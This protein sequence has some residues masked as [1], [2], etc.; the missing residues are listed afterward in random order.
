MNKINKI[1]IWV[2]ALLLVLNITTIGTILYHNNQE[3]E[4]NIAIVLDENQAPLTGRYLRQTL[5]F[6]SEQM[7]VFQKTNREFQP[8]ANRIIYEMDSLKN[9]MFS[10]LNKP[11]PDSI[12][13]NSLSDL[14]GIH[15]SELKKL[16]NNFYL[17]IKSVCDSTQCE[18]LKKTFLSLYQN[19]TAVNRHGYGYNHPD[20]SGIR[21]GNFNRGGRGRNSN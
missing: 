8:Q 13:L 21:R 4:D 11:Q 2:T 9:E 1:L 15:H 10:E 6:N 20:S 19:N 14:I 16:T 3:K 17:K 5:G 12:K 7:E 18:P